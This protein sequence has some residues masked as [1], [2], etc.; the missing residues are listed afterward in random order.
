MTSSSSPIRNV[1]WLENDTIVV[2]EAEGDIDLRR[3]AQ[4]QQDL[5]APLAR[6]PKTVVLDLSNVPYM[7]SSGVASLV[8]LLARVRR[9]KVALKLAGLNARVRSVFEITRLDT[10]FETYPTAEEAIKS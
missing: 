9:D 3:S 5:L 2:M 10:V 6:H 8:K 1:R 7:D 4:F